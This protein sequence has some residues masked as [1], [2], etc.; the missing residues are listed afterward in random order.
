MKRKSLLEKLQ[1]PKYLESLSERRRRELQK[2]IEILGLEQ[3]QYFSSIAVAYK[4]AREK[5]IEEHIPEDKREEY[6]KRP[7]F[8]ID[9]HLKR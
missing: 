1:D 5:W 7:I 6:Y 8:N 4:K 3:L 9:E 2:C